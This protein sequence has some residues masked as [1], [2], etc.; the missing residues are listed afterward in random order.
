MTSAIST[1]NRKAGAL[2]RF[3]AQ[4]ARRSPPLQLISVLPPE[5]DDRLVLI[6]N[7][8]LSNGSDLAR[9]HESEEH[10]NNATS[11]SFDPEAWLSSTYRPTL[12]IVDAARELYVGNDVREISHSYAHNLDETVDMITREVQDAREGGLRTI[13]FVTGVP[14]TQE[15]H[16]L[17][18]KSSTKEAA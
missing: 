2:C 17:G 10:A 18:L 11:T 3:C 6:T 5:S 9:L 1:R 4:P 13:C 7:L 8:V 14:F 15:K 16:W 12:N